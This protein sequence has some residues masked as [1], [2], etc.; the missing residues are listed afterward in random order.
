MRDRLRR[1]TLVAGVIAFG[2]AVAIILVVAAFVMDPRLSAAGV[3]IHFAGIP[4]MT[5]PYDDIEQVWVRNG[6]SV[7]FSTNPLRLLR[8]GGCLH[9]DVVELT[10]RHGWTRTVVVCPW[11]RAGFVR[12]VEARRHP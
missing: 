8:V 9:D 3:E 5:I 12:E 11:D 6:T 7:V 2:A 10:R 1:G 4:V